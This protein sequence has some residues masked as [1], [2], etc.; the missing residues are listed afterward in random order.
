MI[1][2]GRSAFNCTATQKCECSQSSVSWAQRH[3]FVPAEAEVRGVVLTKM[4]N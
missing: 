3:A 4:W 2:T 1:I